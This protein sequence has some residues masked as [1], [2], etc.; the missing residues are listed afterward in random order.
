MPTVAEVLKST[1]FTDEQIA[2]FDQ[3]AIGAFTTVLTT[4]EQE[5]QKGELAQRAANELFEKEITPALNQW[6]SK[7]ATLS[8]ERDYYKTLA[9][10]AKDGGFVAEVPPFQQR[11]QTGQFV[12]NSNAVPGSPNVADLE[13][14][15][16]NAL[17]TLSDLQW[18]YMTLHGKP[19]PDAPTALAAEAAANRMSLDQWAAKKYDFAG[20]EA[21]IKQEQQKAHDDA[22]RKEVAEAKDREW[23][24]KVG[25]NPH[26][27][28][29]QVSQFA[30]LKKGVESGS[31]P[32]PIKMSREQRHAATAQ[33]IRQEVAATV[34]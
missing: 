27:R 14:K 33:A 5:R 29:G 34:N 2:A 9:E 23:A 13:A 19:M 22:I 6:G 28:Q 3:K 17:G 24:E 18:K 21:A 16:G 15:V 26:V 4:A 10:K 30:E 1:G 11:N 7:E 31:R 12:P 8:A 20:R 25:T 32:D